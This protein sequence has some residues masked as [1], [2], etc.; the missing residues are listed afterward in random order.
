MDNSTKAA[1]VGAIIAGIFALAVAFVP[2]MPHFWENTP[3]EIISF[4]SNS[5]SPQESNTSITFTAI[6]I[7]PDNDQIYYKFQMSG[8]TTQNQFE[9]LQNWSTKNEW[10]WHTKDFDIGNNSIRVQIMDKKHVKSDVGDA[11]SDISNFIITRAS[12]ADDWYSL[13]NDLLQHGNY[14]DAIYAYRKGN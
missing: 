5:L 3:P 1:L 14:K 4:Q 6:A 11:Q 8:P 2:S 10:I 13:G 9:D 7:D 12:N